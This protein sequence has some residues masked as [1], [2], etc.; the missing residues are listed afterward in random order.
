MSLP[1]IRD[2][3]VATID[4]QRDKGLAK[5][6]ASLDDADLS[7]SQVAQHLTEELAD[8]LQYAIALFRRMKAQEAE[9]A[10]LRAEN[11]R[12]RTAL[13]PLA[14]LAQGLLGGQEVPTKA[15]AKPA[16]TDRCEACG[17]EVCECE[18]LIQLPPPEPPVT[19]SGLLAQAGAATRRAYTARELAEELG[20][21]KDSINNYNRLGFLPKPLPG[22]GGHPHNPAL[23]E[24]TPQ[25]IDDLK[26]RLHERRSKAAVNGGKT[27][28]AV[29]VAK[30][31][32]KPTPKPKGLYPETTYGEHV[33]QA[34]ALTEAALAARVSFGLIFH[35][36]R[37]EWRTAP[38]APLEPGWGLVL[39]LELS[40]Q[41]WAGTVPISCRSNWL[42]KV[43]GDVLAHLRQG[44]QVKP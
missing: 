15:P 16:Y 25:E 10:A 35:A 44:K 4:A 33:A 6:G 19:L 41:E 43:A 3:A 34:K 40:G 26:K 21:H 38:L 13:L 29:R 24:F 18:A 23:Y 12:L 14:Q 1:T 36:T 42:G 7:P 39:R 28:A 22:T 20:V 11:E 30:A 2:L 5:Y 37:Q 9:V 8:G 27:A 31:K 17:F 32:P